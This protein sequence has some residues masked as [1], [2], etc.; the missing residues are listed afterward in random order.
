MATWY[1][2]DLTL[3][4]KHALTPQQLI[5]DLNDNWP[6]GDFNLY[7]PLTGVQAIL[8]AQPSL[9]YSSTSGTG[10]TVSMDTGVT[11]HEGSGSIQVWPGLGGTSQ[12]PT[13]QAIKDE[14]S[15]IASPFAGIEKMLEFL[16][17]PVRMGEIIGGL[18]LLGVGVNAMLKAS[19]AP[20]VKPTKLIPSMPKSSGNP[21]VQQRG[22]TR[23]QV[24]KQHEALRKALKGNYSG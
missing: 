4:K 20:S 18:I 12:V 21:M 1:A 3:A 6:K 13:G 2:K 8:A 16:L 22:P 17:D 14:V 19:G 5:N 24:N 10:F 7:G 23:A 11:Y 9:K 15:D